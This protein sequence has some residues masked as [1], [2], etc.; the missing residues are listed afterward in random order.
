MQDVEPIA[1]PVERHK[2]DMPGKTNLDRPPGLLPLVLGGKL[3]L[4][5]TTALVITYQEAP[6]LAVYQP[7]VGA[8]VVQSRLPGYKVGDLWA[9]S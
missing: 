1:I 7:Q 9:L 4:W 2:N 3:P 5:L 8:V 6:L